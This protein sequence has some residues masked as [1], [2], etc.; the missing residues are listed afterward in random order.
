MSSYIGVSLQRQIRQ[1]YCDRCAYCQS[2]ESLMAATF[3]VEHI[4]PQSAGGATVI[5][6]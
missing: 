1:Q 2:S 5:T 6:H 4:I 3:E